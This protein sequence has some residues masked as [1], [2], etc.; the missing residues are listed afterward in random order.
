MFC[1]AFGVFI[2]IGC[3]IFSSCGVSF[4]SCVSRCIFGFSIRTNKF[5][6]VLCEYC[7][8]EMEREIARRVGKSGTALLVE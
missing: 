7:W 1:R 8:I 4:S 6:L 2:Q 3:F 5:F